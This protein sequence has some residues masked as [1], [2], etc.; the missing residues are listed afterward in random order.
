MVGVGRAERVQAVGVDVGSPR[1]VDDADDDCDGGDG[2]TH[3]RLREAAS[4]KRDDGVVAVGGDHA[5]DG[6]RQ[7]AEHAVDGRHQ[8]ARA[9]CVAM[10]SARRQDDDAREHGREGEQEIADGQR[11]DQGVRDAVGAPVATEDAQDDDVADDRDEDDDSEQGDDEDALSRQLR[12]RRPERGVVADVRMAEVAQYV[13]HV[14]V[15]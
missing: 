7:A 1:K 8:H 5:Y 4:V 2:V 14:C 12:G 11:R 10:G 6:R 3:G 15:V 13:R 9:V